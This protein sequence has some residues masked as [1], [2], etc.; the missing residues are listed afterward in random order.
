M[1]LSRM[2]AALTCIFLITGM[3]APVL[4]QQFEG[5]LL[6][7][8]VASQVGGDRYSGYNKAGL[9]GGAYIS[10]H[11]KEKF[12]LQMEMAYIQKGS[13]HNDDPDNPDDIDYLFRTDYIE[14][15]LLLRYKATNHIDAEAGFALAAL[16]SHYEEGNGI[17]L[18]GLLP[19]MRSTNLS[20]VAGI[21]YS[22]QDRYRFV[23]RTDNSLLPI[24]KE[25]F[26]GNVKRILPQWGQFHDILVFAL[27]Y[28]L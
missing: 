26:A 25:E 15:P 11:L 23:F 17:N 8:L 24:R 28:R 22:F 14:V 19:A 13:R 2:K 20:F 6:G 3:F 16:V 4:A 10:L 18:K 5:G 12:R 27:F 7:G 21:S 9:T 1:V